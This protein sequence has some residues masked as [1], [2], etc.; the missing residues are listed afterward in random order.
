MG[1][2]VSHEKAGFLGVKLGVLA[3]FPGNLARN[4]GFWRNPWG[5]WHFEV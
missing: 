5:S 4:L 1:E 3:K 2:C